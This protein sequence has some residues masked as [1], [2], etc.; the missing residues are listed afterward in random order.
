[1]HRVHT[2]K[3]TVEEVVMGEP[4]ER[5]RSLSIMDAHNMLHR[6]IN[7]SALLIS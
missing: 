6:E 4:G 1:M 7:C 2:A 3:H 5:A